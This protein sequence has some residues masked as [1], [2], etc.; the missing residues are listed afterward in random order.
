MPGAGG[1]NPRN[2]K[3]RFSRPGVKTPGSGKAS[4][5]QGL[6]PPLLQVISMNVSFLLN[7]AAE[8]RAAS[9]FFLI[10]ARRRNNPTETSVQDLIDLARK[11]NVTLSPAEVEAFFAGLEK[12]DCGRFLPGANALATRFVWIVKGVEA[13]KAALEGQNLE[14][15]ALQALPALP[16]EAVAVP[17]VEM[18]AH[19]LRLRPDLMLSLLLPADLSAAEARRLGLFIAALPL[20]E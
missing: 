10:F 11:Q 8:N 20:E 3:Q 7:L 2:T 5:F 1:F 13:A 4:P 9:V 19:T 18:I 14:W 15:E 17:V 12:A 6:K 16:T